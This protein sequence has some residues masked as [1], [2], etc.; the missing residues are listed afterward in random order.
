MIRDAHLLTLCS[1]VRYVDISPTIV[2][3]FSER[4][5]LSELSLHLDRSLRY[6]AICFARFVNLRLQLPMSYWQ[7]RHCCRS[8]C[9]E[10]KL[11]NSIATCCLHHFLSCRIL[12][13]LFVLGIFGQMRRLRT[14]KLTA[15]EWMF[16]SAGCFYPSPPFLQVPS[17]VVRMTTPTVLAE[18]V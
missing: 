13:T 1:L 8:G 2:N 4:G 11:I 15:V 12:E 16:C 17:C 6:L 14:L 10:S 9:A 5:H 18:A 3:S 7:N